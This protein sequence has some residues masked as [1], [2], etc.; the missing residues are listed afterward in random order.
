MQMT[1]AIMTDES[2]LEPRLREL[3]RLRSAGLHGC[4]FCL[5][6]RAPG[7]EQQEV[8]QVGDPETSD[9]ITERE[10]LALLFT[11]RFN[12]DT[13]AVDEVFL[14]RLQACFTLPEI[15]E[16][17]HVIA[18]IGASHSVNALFDIEAGSG[19]DGY[20]ALVADESEALSSR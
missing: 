11:D 20:D 2:T 19:L 17:T 9:E 3:V 5:S 16:L 10:R 4:T 14:A 18:Y 1:R 13:S 6:T 12:L 8:P 15:V 7:F